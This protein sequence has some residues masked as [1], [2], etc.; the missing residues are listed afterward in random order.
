MPC[1]LLTASPMRG[2]GPSDDHMPSLGTDLVRLTPEL[3][4]SN[5][6]GYSRR[7]PRFP[8]TTGPVPERIPCGPGDLRD[9]RSF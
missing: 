6:D 5:Q 1:V 8:D 7:S 2:L 9:E 3:F 4:V